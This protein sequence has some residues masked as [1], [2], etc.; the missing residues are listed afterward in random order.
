MNNKQKLIGANRLDA[1][2]SIRDGAANYIVAHIFE[3]L[4]QYLFNI[5]LI[6]TAVPEEFRESVGYLVFIV[7]I[8]LIAN[9]LT[10]LSYSKV[11]GQNYYKDM[12]FK[13][14]ISLW[15]FALLVA[16]GILTVFAFAPIANVFVDWIYSLGYKGGTS[17]VVNNIGLYIAYVFIVVLA[18]AFVEEILYRG[19]VARSFK[20]K[21]YIFAIIASSAL[22]AFMHG[23]PVQLVF[24][25]FIAA[26]C[27]ILYFATHSIY[28]PIII[29][30]T[31]N[32]FSITGNYIVSVNNITTIPNSYLIVATIIGIIILP[33]ALYFF[34]K[35]SNKS[36][37]SL[38]KQEKNI[39][40]KFDL[41]FIT[42][43]EM[44]IKED[45]EA[46]VKANL[47]KLDSQEAKEIYLNQVKD[48]EKKNNSTDTKAL[49]LAI[50]LCA[51]IWI[52]Q[53]LMG[54]GVISS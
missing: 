7:T 12:G 36:R 30:A 18:P 41:M 33:V 22:F 21:S 23:N 4:L 20:S 16:I 1:S 25:F 13:K 53:T 32:L 43:K 50:F 24:Q 14:K 8:N 46:L 44:K 9:G 38:I 51:A 37:W 5:V 31:G 35:L 6:S 29:H 49:I 39:N 27:A 42:D 48:V 34:I 10:P 26:V 2:L 54:F 28:V 45:K 47:E 40:K 17:L 3:I 52:L 11:L 15:Q 19:M